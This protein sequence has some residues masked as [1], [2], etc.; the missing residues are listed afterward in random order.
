MDS[1]TLLEDGHHF[2]GLAAELARTF[3][4]K[5]VEISFKQDQSPVTFADQS[6]EKQIRAAILEKHP[7]HSIL[8]E[9]FGTE[10]ATQDHLWVIDP[11]DGTRSFLSGNPLFG[12]L[13]S[14]LE[15]RDPQ[16]GI[17]GMPAL[18]ETYCGVKGA[19]ATCNGAEIHVSS[20]TNLEEAVLYV[21]E[22]EKIY[23]AHPAVFAKL[24]RSGQTRRFAYDCYP[25]AL[26]AAGHVDAVVDYDLK[27][28]DFLALGPVVEGAGGIMTTWA[29]QKPDLTYEGP[30]I[31]A[32]T[33]QLHAQLVDLLHVEQ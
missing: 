10:G 14:Y 23:D 2:A 24:M 18:G 22:G 19:A 33:P 1:A 21:N 25:H 15:A 28:Y 31:S 29:G 9:E 8:G 7:D 5:P 12:F 6:I 11:I 3:F 27:P 32:A 17:I 16:L 13:L 20:Q 30:I 26:L 4:R